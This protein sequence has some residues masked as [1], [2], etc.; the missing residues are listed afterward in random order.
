MR[1]A[2]PACGSSVVSASQIDGRC[3]HLPDPF[4]R[5]VGRVGRTHAFADQHPQSGAARTGFF[6]RFDLAHADVGGKFLAFG[7]GAF[8]VGRAAVQRLL[9]R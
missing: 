5:E 2:S 3:H 1:P 4:G 8:G 9:D 6:Q 7:D